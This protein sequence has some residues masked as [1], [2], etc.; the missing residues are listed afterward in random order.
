MTILKNISPLYEEIR[1]RLDTVRKKQNSVDL[2]TGITISISV[3]LLTSCISIVL[4]LIFG[5]GITGRTILF[6]FI[7]LSLLFSSLWFVGKP[8]LRKLK[9]LKNAT[10]SDTATKVGNQFPNI[11]DRLLNALQIYESKVREKVLYSI[12]LIDAS[13]IDLYDAIK[14]INFI[15]AVDYKRFKKTRKFFLYAVSVFLLALIISPKGFLWSAFRIYQFN[16]Q[17][18]VIPKLFFIIEPGDSEALRGETVDFTIHPVGSYVNTITFLSR[19]EGV[20]KYE[21]TTLNISDKGTFKFS[22]PNI[23]ST[24]HYYVSSGDASSPV[25]K[26]SVLER[27]II[28]SLQLSLNYPAYTRIPPKILE[29]NIG[30]VTALPGTR[31]AFNI[32]SSKK[33][34]LAELHYNDGGVTKLILSDAE[35]KGSLVLLKEKKYTILLKDES[36]LT[37]IEPVE[38]QLKLI[39][40]EFPTASIILPGKSVDITENLKLPLL[41]RIRDDFGFTHLRLAHRLTQS[42]YEKP[43]EEFSFVEIALTLKDQVTQEVWYEWNLSGLNLVPE[44]VLTYY[45]EVFDNDNVSGPKSGRSETYLVRLPSLDEVFADV[46]QSQQQTLE[47]MQTMAKEAEKMKKEL[48]ELQREVKK[49]PQKMDWQQQKKAEELTTKYNEMRKKVSET[50]KK[51]EEIIQK[52]DE[53]KLLSNQTMEKFQEMQKLMDQINNPELQQAMKK[54]QESM[55]QMTPEQMKQAMQQMQLSEE[56]FRKN[57]ERMIELL[58]RIAIEQKIDELIK[59]TEELIKQQQELQNQ[60]AR[61]NPKDEQ[62]LSD[63]ARQQEDMQKKIDKLEQEAKSLKEKMEEFPEDMPTEKM[64]KAQKDLANKKLQQKAK[65]SAQQMKSGEMKQSDQTQ[66]E[67]QEDLEDFMSQ[68]QDVKE[69]LQ[70][71]MQKEVLNKMRKAV[72]DL[73]ELSKKQ[74]ALKQETQKLDPNS[75]RFRENAQQQMDMMGDLNNVANSMGEISKKSFAISPDMGKE[76]GNAMKQMAQSLQN[77]EQRNPP[78]ASQKQSEAMG[79]CNRAAMM[80]QGAI[81][82]MKQGGGKGMGMAGLMQRLG[83]MSGMQMGINQQTGQAMGQGQGLTQQQMAEY[84]RIAGQQGAARKALEQLIEEAKN[85][86][87]LS[88]LLGDLERI[89]KDMLEVQTDLEQSNVNPETIKKQEKIL[90]RMLDSQRSMRERDFEKRRRAEVGKDYKYPSPADIDL[91]SQDGRNKLREELLKMLE[92]KYSKDY[93]DLIRKYFEALEKE[94]LE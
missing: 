89:A 4:D 60:T 9:I 67:M 68:M 76:I 20:A 58:K 34:S 56:Q 44:D 47:T 2:F 87:E 15:Q 59:R 1:H 24:T 50:A 27:P 52:M 54:L 39:Q 93:E 40:D 35:A 78:A 53:N 90:S 10:D 57:L 69:S 70:E 77:M 8:L 72:Q 21:K 36:G 94:K 38:Y 83:Q 26:I 81:N 92:E 14:D 64:D 71:Q 5:F 30:D 79:S 18:S 22:I 42:R 85:A 31:I 19:E 17:F 82:S 12:E 91:T 51:M 29:E 23:K 43:A 28:R 3:L 66:Q 63:L 55:K 74:E 37:N 80:M 84:G 16:Q 73:L 49:N 45:I 86:G 6:F 32:I 13:F 88:K 62:K 11:H 33:L 25:Y 48:D 65:K 7:V 41:T 75:Q 46:A 61:T